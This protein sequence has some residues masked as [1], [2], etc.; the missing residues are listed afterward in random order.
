MDLYSDMARHYLSGPLEKGEKIQ[1]HGC[2]YRR[3]TDGCKKKSVRQRGPVPSDVF[4]G[5]VVC[6]FKKLKAEPPR[7]RP[8]PVF[9]SPEDP[10]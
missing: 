8:C 6:E 10:L 7:S 3:G 2:K 9:G 4:F 1:C 5:K